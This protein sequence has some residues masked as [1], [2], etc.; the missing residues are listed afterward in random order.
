[1]MGSSDSVCSVAHAAEHEGVSVRGGEVVAGERGAWV[2]FAV[3]V[4]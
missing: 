1:M 4:G 2:G 3:T